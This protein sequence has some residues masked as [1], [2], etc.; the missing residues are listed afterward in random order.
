MEGDLIT[1]Q[2]N[3]NVLIFDPYFIQYAK[4]WRVKMS[5]LKYDLKNM[6]KLEI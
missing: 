1:L 4:Q 2:I 5:A 3:L 6:E